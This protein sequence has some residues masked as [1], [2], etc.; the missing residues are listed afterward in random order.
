[1]EEALASA[2]AFEELAARDAEQRSEQAWTKCAEL[3]QRDD[4]LAAFA[5]AVAQAKA[6]DDSNFGLVKIEI[7][8]YPY[9]SVALDT[10]GKPIWRPFNGRTLLVTRTCCCQSNYWAI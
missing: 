8:V 3:A 10:Q 2:V 6:P 4:I 1:M 5:E 7:D 9:N